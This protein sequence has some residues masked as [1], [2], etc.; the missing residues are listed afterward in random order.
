MAHGE[1]PDRSKADLTH[2]PG[3]H[4]R[5]WRRQCT[6]CLSGVDVSIVLYAHRVGWKVVTEL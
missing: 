1:K 3:E 5:S 4:A 2:V 6:I